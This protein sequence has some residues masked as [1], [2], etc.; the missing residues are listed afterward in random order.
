MRRAVF[1]I[2]GPTING[3]IEIGGKQQST[4]FCLLFACNI[5]VIPQLLTARKRFAAD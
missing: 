3:G 4:H 5:Q 2:R 1:K